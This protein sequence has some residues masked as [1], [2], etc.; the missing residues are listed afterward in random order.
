MKGVLTY[1]ITLVGIALLASGCSKE[2]SLHN[3]D[4]PTP[5]IT[6]RP[7]KTITIRRPKSVRPITAERPLSVQSDEPTKEYDTLSQ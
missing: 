7:N 2:D 5:P 4:N 6:K 3:P 1:A